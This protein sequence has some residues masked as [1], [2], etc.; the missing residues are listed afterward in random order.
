MGDNNESGW[1]F[2]D[3]RFTSLNNDRLI[4]V[5]SNNSQQSSAFGNYLQG[6]GWKGATGYCVCTYSFYR[7]IV[8]LL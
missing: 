6:Q 4:R 1:V 5:T 2:N 8:Y 3:L 7:R